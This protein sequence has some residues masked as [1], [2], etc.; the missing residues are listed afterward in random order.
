MTAS[1]YPN[2]F[3]CAIIISRTEAACFHVV[4]VLFHHLG[5]PLYAYLSEYDSDQFGDVIPDVLFPMALDYHIRSRV[6]DVNDLAAKE[7]GRLNKKRKK[8]KAIKVRMNLFLFLYSA[9]LFTILLKNIQKYDYIQKYT[10][11]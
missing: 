7:R 4:F 1:L 10:E 3:L 2:I 6:I 9:S 8:N 11:I 5:T